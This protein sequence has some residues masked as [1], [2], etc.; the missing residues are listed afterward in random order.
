[1]QTRLYMHLGTGLTGR[2]LGHFPSDMGRSTLNLGD[3]LIVATQILVSSNYSLERA[4]LITPL[5]LRN[6][7]L[8]LGIIGL[9]L[10]I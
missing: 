1:M 7:L 2:N 4:M 9:L 10:R 5:W 6:R 8:T 3:S